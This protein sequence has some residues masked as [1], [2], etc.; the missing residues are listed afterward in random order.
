[1]VGDLAGHGASISLAAW[2][3]RQ[4]LGNPAVEQPAA[5]QAHLFDHQGS[6]LL[7]AE[8]VVW[9]TG[10][11]SGPF[12]SDET[13]ARQ[14]FQ[15]RD[16]LVFAAT[17]GRAQALKVER[18]PHDGR[19]GQQLAA[20]LC[21]RGQ[22]G[23]EQAPH[24]R[25]NIPRRGIH[26]GCPD[27]SQVLDHEQ[28]QA[29]A[30]VEQA[31]AQAAADFRRG[32]RGRIDQRGYVGP[33]PA[34]QKQA[35]PQTGTLCLFHHAPQSLIRGAVLVAPGQQHKHRP[36]AQSPHQVCQHVQCRLVRPLQVVQEQNA[37]LRPRPVSAPTRP[38]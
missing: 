12:L 31:L 13:L 25:R 26:P 24:A 28:R 30:L 10:G 38:G 35:A 29:F 34:R 16:R 22:V 32:R 15:G 37:R 8:V 18:P 5:R 23:L 17:T 21:R 27:G 19:C 7:V 6:Q 4:R 11:H 33:A 14:K 2:P 1:M 9:L 3:G 36:A 20:S